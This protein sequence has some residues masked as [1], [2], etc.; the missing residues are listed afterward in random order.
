MIADPRAI[1]AMFLFCYAQHPSY[2]LRTIFLSL[3]I[4]QHYTTFDSHT[5]VQ[6]R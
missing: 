2:L 5:K 3:G 4:L 1:F 6:M